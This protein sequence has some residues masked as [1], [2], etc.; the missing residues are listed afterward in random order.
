MAVLRVVH[1]VKNAF[2]TV[3]M[4]LV[5]HKMP[6]WQLAVIFSFLRCW[7]GSLRCQTALEDLVPVQGRLFI[8]ETMVNDRVLE[9][10]EVCCVEPGINAVQK[11]VDK[12]GASEPVYDRRSDTTFEVPLMCWEARQCW[13]R[14]IE[15]PSFRATSWIGGLP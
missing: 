10:V 14:V 13:E 1:I 8:D 3:V 4:M 5:V 6:V 9:F 11:Y 7:S 12:I 2:Q 15:E